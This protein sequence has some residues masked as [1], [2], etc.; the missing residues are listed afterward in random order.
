MKLYYFNE[1][2]NYGDALNPW[3]WPRLLGHRLQERSSTLFLGIGTILKP[4]LP[5]ADRYVVLGSGGGYE[6][7][8]KI[9]HRWTFYGVRGPLTAQG[10]GLDPELALLDGAYLLRNLKSLP[11]A[12]D[13]PQIGFMPH[14][15]TQLSLPW[16]KICARSGLRYL[17]PRASVD[18]VLG[19]LQGCRGVIAEAMHAAITA[20][21]LRIPWLPVR[22]GR[23][24]LDFKWRDWLASISMDVAPIPLPAVE[25]RFVARNRE[26]AFRRLCRQTITPLEN[27]LQINTLIRRLASLGREFEANL[28]IGHLSSQTVLCAQTNRLNRCLE[29]LCDKEN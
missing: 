29:R 10:L 14:W 18:E 1:A 9:D 17:D 26:S 28:Q 7:F 11:T 19:Q 5:P 13:G 21:I 24:I 6:A 2:P 22:L 25:P 27:E 20:D 3:L 12:I 8:P 16:E 15:Q 23:H 4:G